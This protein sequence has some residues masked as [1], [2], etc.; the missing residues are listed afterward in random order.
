MEVVNR[1]FNATM[2][3]LRG[4]VRFAN[5]NP[6]QFAKRMGGLALPMTFLAN[7]AYMDSDLADIMNGVNPEE[8]AKYVWG[9]TGK[10]IKKD[11]KGR[12]VEGIWRIPVGEAARPFNG[13]IQGLA[14]AAHAKGA[15]ADI[16]GDMA[17]SV[18]NNALPMPLTQW[19]G[20]QVPL[21]D[22]P[23]MV[24]GVPLLG[25]GLEVI[26]NHN[27]FSGSPLLT[28]NNVKKTPDFMKKFLSPTTA[29]AAWHVAKSLMPP[30]QAL[31]QGG[32][33]RYTNP[34][35][36]FTTVTQG[37]SRRLLKERAKIKGLD[38]LGG[39]Q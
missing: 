15:T 34:L 39:S 24:S 36:R 2:Q 4:E 27:L 38:N 8:R 28:P 12:V 19:A 13:I 22:I 29:T 35:S 18:L 33:D 3:G 9:R 17:M 7:N 1:Y 20:G 5:H 26:S 16:V 21:P 32:Q 25:S 30:I 31:E 6:K 10:P 11:E 37:Q 14:H 23:K